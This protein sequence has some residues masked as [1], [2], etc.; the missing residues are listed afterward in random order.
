M[1]TRLFPNSR[2]DDRR[3]GVVFGQGILLGTGCCCILRRCAGMSSRQMDHNE[4]EKVW[5]A[6]YGPKWCGTVACLR[7]DKA[8]NLRSQSH[9][10][11][12]YGAGVSNVALSKGGLDNRR[13]RNLHQLTTHHPGTDDARPLSIV[14]FQT[15]ISICITLFCIYFSDRLCT[16]FFCG[17]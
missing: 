10:K 8:G 15:G 2:S 16:P 7:K 17:R 4:R 9:P 11:A 5:V 3:T 1:P 6:L 14:G 13:R 12:G